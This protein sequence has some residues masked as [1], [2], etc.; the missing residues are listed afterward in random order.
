MFFKT[1]YPTIVEN[2]KQFTL[3]CPHCGNKSIHQI[4]EFYEGPCIGFIFLSKP[5]IA[6][7]RY[8]LIC[9]ICNNP[10]KELTVQQVQNS[11]GN[12]V[13]NDEINQIEVS[14][15]CKNCGA[16]IKKNFIFCKHC[17]TRL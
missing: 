1:Y 3:I 16:A 15:F 13:I 8:Y 2:T 17:G 6:S 11:R 9:Q 7:K 5:L 12:G 10:T 14:N 4:Y